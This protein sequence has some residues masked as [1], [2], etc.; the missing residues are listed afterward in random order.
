MIS[1]EAKATLYWCD[2]EKNTECRKTGCRY[3]LT[4]EEGG[5]CEATFRRAFARTDPDGVP[6]VYEKQKEF[7]KAKKAQPK[8]RKY[9]RKK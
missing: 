2:P 7:Q 5:V 8:R 3:L 1:M 4:P 9:R 6:M